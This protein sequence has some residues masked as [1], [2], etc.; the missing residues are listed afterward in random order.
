MNI[1]PSDCEGDDE[2]F[3]EQEGREYEDW[4]RDSDYETDEENWDINYRD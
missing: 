1:P 3:E 2:V 4:I